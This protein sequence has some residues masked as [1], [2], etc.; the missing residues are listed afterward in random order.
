MTAEIYSEFEPERE[1]E[2]KTGIA[3]VFSHEMDQNQ[4]IDS[5]TKSR[6]DKA[7]ELYKS[8]QVKYFEVV[9]GKF[10][11][12]MEV[13]IADKMQEYLL[14]N[15]VEKDNIITERISIDSITNILFG[16]LDIIKKFGPE[17]FK[18]DEKIYFDEDKLKELFKD[19]TKKYNFYWVSSLY[20]LLRIKKIVKGNKLHTD[21]QE[22][23]SPKTNKFPDGI[24]GIAAEIISHTILLGDK[25]GR[26]KIMT[27]LRNSDR[28]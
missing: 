6:L 23:V 18:T 17:E 13:P 27:K 11:K 26:G 28:R 9:G 16:Y 22:F 7:L 8:G 21:E 24:K 3:F 10:R 15:G 12:G 14:E 4:E 25:T 1:Q 20:H 5:E 2:K 19:I